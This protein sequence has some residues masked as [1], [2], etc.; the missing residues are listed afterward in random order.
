MNTKFVD[1]MHRNVLLNSMIYTGT[2]IMDTFSIIS[3]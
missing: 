1:N 2:E 3:G